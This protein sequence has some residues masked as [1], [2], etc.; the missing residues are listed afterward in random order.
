[1]TCRVA[2][3]GAGITAAVLWAVAVVVVGLSFDGDRYTNVVLLFVAAAAAATAIAGVGYFL[4]KGS[5]EAV[6]EMGRR[7]GVQEGLME[8]Q[9]AAEGG[10]V[11]FLPRRAGL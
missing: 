4:S 1:M 2:R 3:R 8:R 10:N 7:A 11:A 6:F 9:A 5:A